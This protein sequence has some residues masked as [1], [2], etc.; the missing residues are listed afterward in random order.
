MQQ[1]GAEDVLKG[2]L[3]IYT[4]VDMTLQKHAEDAIARRLAQID[5][6]GK[7]EG[8]LVAIDPHTRRS[9]GAGRRSRFSHELVQSRNAGEAAAGL[10]VQTVAVRGGDRAGVHAELGR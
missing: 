1:F 5:K 7:L 9:A 3:R 6:T 8:A 4:T 2:G 10:R